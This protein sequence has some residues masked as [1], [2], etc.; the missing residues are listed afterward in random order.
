MGWRSLTERQVF[1]LET[2]DFEYTII[3]PINPDLIPK[4]QVE[5]VLKHGEHDQKTHGSWANGN[6]YD[7]VEAKSEILMDEWR[8]K[9]GI[10]SK[11][12][13]SKGMTRSWNEIQADPKAKK[14]Q[15]GVDAIWEKMQTNQNKF[16]DEHFEKNETEDFD[17]L[18]DKYVVA[19]T[20]T[21]KMNKQLRE[22]GGLTQRVKDADALCAM[23]VVKERVGVY[24]GAFLPKE[25]ID[26]IKVGTS[27][28]DKGF[29]STDVDKSSAQ[30][31]ARSRKEGG[32]QGELVLFRYTLEKGL[33]AIDVSYGEVVVQ[34]N[35]TITVTKK[36]KS[37]EY[38]IIDATVN[39]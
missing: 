26:T 9:Y 2:K 24:R 21:L 22:G 6:S 34:R 10:L 35:A 16:Y 38:T 3:D 14:M 29:Q 31:Y 28:T 30:F 11:Y 8:K 15:E 13:E 20:P 36:T 25:L 1:L 17:R 7:E 37:G 5:D 19:D 23:G 32:A 12:L 27:F 39:K 18:R 4:P 33:N